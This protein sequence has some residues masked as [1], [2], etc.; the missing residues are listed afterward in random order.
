[1]Y[2][3]SLDWRQTKHNYTYQTYHNPPLTLLAHRCTVVNRAVLILSTVSDS[4]I[5]VIII[6]SWL[7]ES[8]TSLNISRDIYFRFMLSI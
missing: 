7:G 3:G 2:D 8:K 1:M 6:K 5:Q 4:F